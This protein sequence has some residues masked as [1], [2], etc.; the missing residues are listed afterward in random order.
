MCK[1]INNFTKLGIQLDLD[2]E[3]ICLNTKKDTL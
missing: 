2:D 3:T 1:Y